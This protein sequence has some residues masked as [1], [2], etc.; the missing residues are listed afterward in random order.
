MLY[1]G[2]TRGYKGP[3]VLRQNW[4]SCSLQCQPAMPKLAQVLVALFLPQPS[5]N[6]PGKEV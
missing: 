4:F 1:L 6:L 5:A 2:D 3:R